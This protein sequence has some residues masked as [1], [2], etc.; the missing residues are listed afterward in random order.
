MKEGLMWNASA[1]GGAG[2]AGNR[3]SER[4]V[5]AIL[6]FVINQYSITRVEVEPYPTSSEHQSCLRD[7]GT[8]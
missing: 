3:G 7:A 6:G 5:E 2:G 8:V 1:G 4:I